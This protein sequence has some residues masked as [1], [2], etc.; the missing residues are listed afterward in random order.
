MKLVVHEV[1][2]IERSEEISPVTVG[3]T[4]HEGKAFSLPAQEVRVHGA[5][6]LPY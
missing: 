3:L 5:S 1:A 2:I 4:I 6:A